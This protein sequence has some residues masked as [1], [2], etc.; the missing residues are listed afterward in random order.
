MMIDRGS[1]RREAEGEH[2]QARELG[3]ET[4]ARLLRHRW[5]ILVESKVRCQISPRI[6][7]YYGGII[8]FATRQNWSSSEVS[9]GRDLQA[10]PQISP[11]WECIARY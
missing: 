7:W 8:I 1:G 5:L 9:T 3:K 2:V 10:P 6:E 11:L 4:D